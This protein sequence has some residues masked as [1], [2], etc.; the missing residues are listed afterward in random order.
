MAGPSSSS[1][2]SIRIR[3]VIVADSAASYSFLVARAH[4]LSSFSPTKIRL[5]IVADPADYHS[6]VNSS[7]FLLPRLVSS[8]LLSLFSY[9][10]RA[11]RHGRSK[12]ILLP[13]WSTSGLYGLLALR[14]APGLAEIQ[15][16]PDWEVG[17]AH[18][19]SPAPVAP[20]C[21]VVPHLPAPCDFN[22][23]CRLAGSRFSILRSR[24]GSL[25]HPWVAS[26][27]RFTSRSRFFTKPCACALHSVTPFG[28]S[29]RLG[30]KLLVSKHTKCLVENAVR[31][32][33]Q[34]GDCGLA[35]QFFLSPTESHF[36]VGPHFLHL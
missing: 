34:V 6:P 19:P 16:R 4:N 29:C 28:S 10:A 23:R 18:G 27:P 31:L 26:R 30:S 8:H 9:P 17:Q 7:S 15:L 33:R 5:V 1:L 2:T 24:Y 14:E 12:V 36:L 25:L 3:L 13:L 22:G 11:S 20:N 35:F 32:D 21:L